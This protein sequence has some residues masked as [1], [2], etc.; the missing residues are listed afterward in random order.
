MTLSLSDF[1]GLCE[2]CGHY[3]PRLSY[4]DDSFPLEDGSYEKGYFHEWKICL[5]CTQRHDFTNDQLL[6]ELA[7]EREEIERSRWSEQ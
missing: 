4:Y 6:N 1:K 7:K 2:E 5:K 3:S